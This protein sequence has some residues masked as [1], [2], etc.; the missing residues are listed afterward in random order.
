MEEDEERMIHDFTWQVCDKINI[1]AKRDNDDRSYH[2]GLEGF[3][4]TLARDFLYDSAKKEFR[5][6]KTWCL[7]VI[8]VVVPQYQ[9]FGGNLSAKIQCVVSSSTGDAPLADVGLDGRT[10][11]QLVN[12]ECSFSR[13]RFISTSNIHGGKKFH[14]L[15]SLWR[16][17]H[18]VVAYISTGISVYSRKDA[19][20]KRKKAK[21]V[22]ETRT[23][24][25]PFRVF[26]PSLFD[27]DFV[28]K[29]NDHK[30]HTICEK[31][32]NSVAGLVNY[33]QAPNIRAKCRHPVFL[34]CK[35]SNVLS[36]ARNANM[37]PN[38]TKQEMFYSF[39]SDLGMSKYDGAQTDQKEVAENSSY[40]RWF[41]VLKESKCLT[42]E[43]KR[44]ISDNMSYIECR[45]IGFVTSPALL[46]ENYQ[47]VENV[48][49]L[50]QTYER[51]YSSFLLTSDSKAVNS[52]EIQDKWD[53]VESF[54]WED[55]VSNIEN[56][57]YSSPDDSCNISVESYC[58]VDT[59]AEHYF[60]I[61][62]QIRQL[63]FQLLDGATQCMREPS[64]ETVDKLQIV[65]R[66]FFRLLRAHAHAE[67]TIIFPQLAKKIPG[68]TEAYHLDHFMEGRELASLGDMIEN[69]VPEM[70][71]DVFRKVSSFSA[72][73]LQ[74]MEKEEEHL[75]PYLVHVFSDHEVAIL[76][77]RVIL[78][79]TSLL[80]ET[81]QT[82]SW[83][84]DASKEKDAIDLR[85]YLVEDS[86]E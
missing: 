80:G 82:H 55:V 21:D 19:D 65:Y 9:Q 54:Q 27:K 51:C 62:Q 12:G 75:I 76:K 42:E 61:H 15:L 52:I 64:S 50:R 78:E 59:L 7:P 39:L 38:E 43:A 66:S 40:P 35:F 20:K 77:E 33:F 5:W 49:L 13:L 86:K 14:L 56:V 34:L 28:K 17:S 68:I 41:I 57:S 16:E 37:F 36:L 8:E 6:H 31:I 60:R 70:A 4:I 63:L 47:L 48:V 22:L 73:F 32:D 81:T 23:I 83:I 11:Q 29:V 2:K 79:T 3:K 71:N 18:C 84:E 67:D 85:R 72:R 69:F 74:H 26:S 24:E 10:V 44:R 30:G 25:T 1:S 46:P 45:L 58:S 53:P